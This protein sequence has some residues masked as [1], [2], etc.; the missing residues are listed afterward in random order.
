M[1]SSCRYLMIALC[2]A[3]ILLAG[4][5]PMYA[6]GDTASISG[7]ERD[8]SGAV[9]PGADVA[10]RNESTG[11][12]RRTKTNESGYYVMTGLPPST[13]T[14]SASFAGFKRSD[15]TGLVLTSAISVNAVT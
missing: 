13:Y 11:V 10:V 4:A 5:T 7:I 3:I 14:V 15:K 12:E 9:L 6:Q 2:T 1:S 8:T